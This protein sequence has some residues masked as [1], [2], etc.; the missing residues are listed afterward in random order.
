MNSID[1][2]YSPHK[3]NRLSARLSRLTRTTP[4]RLKTALGVG[5]ALA[6]A[7]CVVVLLGQAQHERA[8][9]TLGNDAAPSVVAAH[10]IR[11][12]I[13]TLDADLANDLRRMEL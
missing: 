9:K 2:E 1:L 7:L 4:A 13:E 11:I 12:Y 6:G 10:K 5:W 8:A 3:S